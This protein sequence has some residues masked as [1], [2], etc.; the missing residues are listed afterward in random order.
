MSRTVDELRPVAQRLANEH[1]EPCLIV[2]T[3]P[4]REGDH[5]R[6]RIP[7]VVLLSQSTKAE[8]NSAVE[9]VGPNN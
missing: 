7:F 5:M 3:P 6:G 8:Q 4:E 9:K 1:H 2:E